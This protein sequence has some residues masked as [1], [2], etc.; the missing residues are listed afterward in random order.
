MEEVLAM[1]LTHKDVAA[2]LLTAFAVFAFVAARESWNVWL[3]GSSNRWAAG[4]ILLLGLGACSLG[5]PGDEAGKAPFTIVLSVVGVAALAFAVWAIWTAAATA[6]ALL[7]CAVVLLWVGATARHLA[8]P[9][10]GSV[11]T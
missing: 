1:A 11:P 10:Q 7:V 6:L 3:I 4:A 8:H 2:T 9:K 5:A